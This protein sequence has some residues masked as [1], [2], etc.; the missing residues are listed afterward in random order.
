M[1]SQENLGDPT[2][3][4]REVFFNIVELEN[5]YHLSTE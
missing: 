4:Y 2:L 3:R 1:F 5:I